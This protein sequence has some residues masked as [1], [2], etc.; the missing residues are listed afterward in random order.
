MCRGM[1]SGDGSS[2]TMRT[3][4]VLNVGDSSMPVKGCRPMSA[5]ELPRL[6]KLVFGGDEQVGTYRDVNVIVV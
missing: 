2:D 3:P 4:E 6:M 5:F 1:D